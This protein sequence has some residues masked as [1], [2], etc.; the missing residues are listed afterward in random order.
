LITK[1]RML[2]FFLPNL[3]PLNVRCSLDSGGTVCC[4]SRT[5]TSGNFD[6]RHI[7]NFVR[8][9]ACTDRNCMRPVQECMGRIQGMG[10]QPGDIV[11]HATINGFAATCR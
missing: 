6:T 8:V 2:N 11:T 5:L 9:C 4:K 1:V 7:V 10:F 3:E